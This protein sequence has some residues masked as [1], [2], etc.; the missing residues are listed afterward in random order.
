MTQFLFDPSLGVSTSRL[1]SMF[2]FPDS[3]TVHLQCDILLCDKEDCE[4]PLCVTDPD[5]ETG[6]SLPAPSSVSDEE[7][8][9][10]R[11]MAST[12]VFVVEPGVTALGN[13]LHPCCTTCLVPDFFLLINQYYAFM[14][15]FIRDTT[16]YC[17]YDYYYDSYQISFD[18]VHI[19]TVFNLFL[20]LL[21][22]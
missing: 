14:P 16:R 7:D 15:S 13:T 9:K 4:E 11:M 2:R 21:H 5:S 10:T 20:V 19:R 1:Y 18:K 17:Y 3:N 12:T 6:R 8:D 22:I